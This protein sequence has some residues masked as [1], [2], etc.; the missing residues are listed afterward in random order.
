[1]MSG[2]NGSMDVIEDYRIRRSCKQR[3]RLKRLYEQH[4][5][6][7][8]L[9]KEYGSDIMNSENFNRTKEH[10]QHGT[11]SVH[12]HC[13]DVARYSLLINKKLGLGCNKEDLVRGALLHDYFLY[14]WHDKEYL[15]HRKRLHGFHHPATALRNAEKEYNLSDRQRDIIRKHMWPLTIVPPICE[16]AWVVT[17]ADKYC[18]FRE[19]LGLKKGHGKQ[20]VHG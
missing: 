3:E 10:I 4:K 8:A 2:E 16:E 5:R 6:I 14:D 17:V 9:L 15:A 13:M 20:A 12:N 18:S 7:Q 11:I 1:M 19:T